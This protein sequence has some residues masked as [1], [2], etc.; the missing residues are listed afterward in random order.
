MNLDKL[1]AGGK[2]PDFLIRKGVRR[3][4]KKRIKKQNKLSIAERFEYLAHFIKELKK[5]PIAVETKA[6]NEQH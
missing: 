6:A 4:V 5:Q 3:L 1:L 2:V